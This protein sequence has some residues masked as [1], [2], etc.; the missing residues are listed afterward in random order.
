VYVA[1]AGNNRIQV[2]T[3]AGGYLMQWGIQGGDDG[4]IETP[5]GIAVDAAGNVYVSDT[6][7]DRVQKFGAA[8]TT[9]TTTD[10]YFK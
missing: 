8:A 10:A 6:G 4:E 3:G 9:A 1:D 7:N 2:F 5:S